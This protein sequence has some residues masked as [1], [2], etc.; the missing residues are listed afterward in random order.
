MSMTVQTD[1]IINTLVR[2]QQVRHKKYVN[3]PV[4]SRNSRLSSLKS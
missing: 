4:L 3:I 1:N 2:I